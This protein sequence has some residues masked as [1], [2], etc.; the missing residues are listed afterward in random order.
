VLIPAERFANDEHMPDWAP[1]GSAFVFT[2]D[3]EEAGRFLLR[4]ADA[5]AMSVWTIKVEGVTPVWSPDGEWIAYQ[6]MGAVGVVSSD[7][8]LKRSWNVGW[9]KGITWSPE[10]DM[11][12]G[13]SNGRRQIGL[14]DVVTGQHME[15]PYLGSGI[16]AVA[17][18]PDQDGV[19]R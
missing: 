3:W 17:W 10:S 15:L 18:R 4:V 13:I 12:V 14:L 1:D 8:A 7:G 6:E 2:A 16:S 11:L 5:T 19:V 9:A